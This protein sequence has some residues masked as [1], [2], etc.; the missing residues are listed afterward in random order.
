MAESPD[1]ETGFSLWRRWAMGGQVVAAAIASLA[2]VIM[3]NYLSSR[4]YERFAASETARH[5]L[6]PLTR[7]MLADLTNQVTI[8][9]FFDPE[10]S[11]LFPEVRGLLSEYRAAAERLKVEYV[12]Y[13]RNPGR[14]EFLLSQYGI[15]SSTDTLMVVFDA[16]GRPPRIVREKELSDYDF[17]GALQGQPIKRIGFKG[18]QFFTSALLTLADPRPIRAYALAGHGEANL[19]SES[20]PDGYSRFARLLAEK[21]ILLEPLELRTNG[22][23]ENCELLIIG[24]PR[25]PIATAELQQIDRYLHSGGRALILLPSPARPGVRQSG[26]E[27]VLK[28]WGVEVVD[29]LVVD[30]AQSQ[31][32][33]T[34]VLLTGEFGNH[35]VVSPLQG[36]RLGLIMPSCVRPLTATG[37]QPEGSRVD[38]LAFTSASGIVVTPNSQTEAT[39]QT[40]GIIPLAVAAEQGTIAGVSPDRGAVRL[41]VVG[42]STFLSNQLIEF[43]A[44]QDFGSLAV[45][46]L[47]DREQWQ[48]LGARPIREYQINLTTPQLHGAAWVLLGV[49]P[50]SALAFGLVI[51]MRRRR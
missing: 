48:H 41:V 35:P 21:N 8:T 12:N 10:E 32:G 31:A 23:P 1:P 26:L 51:W 37:Q 19:D 45:N 24:G 44:N 14:A 50:G 33:D 36:A 40:N 13:G 43:E 11:A 9:V 38:P 4:H 47:V 49:L 22:V 29:G 25:F 39:V 30:E 27:S 34:R 20:A 3:V 42:E 18:E 7:A 6:S 5:S 15:T 17:S 16:E 46:W 2:I 28:G